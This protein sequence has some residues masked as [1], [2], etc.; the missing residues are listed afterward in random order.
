M[1][2]TI[3]LIENALSSCYLRTGTTSVVCS[4]YLEQKNETDPR[5]EVEFPRQCLSSLHV[6]IRSFVESLLITRSRSTQVKVSLYAIKEGPDLFSC[7]VNALS[8]CAIF[9]GLRIS[10]TICSATIYVDSQ[11][12]K[13]SEIHGEGLFPVHMAY[14]LYGKKVGQIYFNGPLSLE[15]IPN[16]MNELIST[17]SKRGDWIKQRIEELV[18]S[19]IST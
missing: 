19:K 18:K 15:Y 4:I 3:G 1:D 7:Y 16:V 10:D 17:C 13:V 2:V 12:G 6:S 11:E 5:V 8:I 9:S 14:G